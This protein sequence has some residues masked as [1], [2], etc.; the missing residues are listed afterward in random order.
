MD[1]Q[2]QVKKIKIGH[3]EKKEYHRSQLIIS[4]LG[5]FFTLVL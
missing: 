2:E 5:H 1:L 3:S 4:Y